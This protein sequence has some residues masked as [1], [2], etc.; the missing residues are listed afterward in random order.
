MLLVK[1]ITYHDWWREQDTDLSPREQPILLNALA[2]LQIKFEQERHDSNDRIAVNCEA[3]KTSESTANLC[4]WLNA[5]TVVHVSEEGRKKGRR[6][7]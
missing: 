2:F 3:E 6:E 1:D 5:E 4:R 7:P